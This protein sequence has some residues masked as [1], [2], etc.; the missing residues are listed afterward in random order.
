VN[1]ALPPVFERLGRNIFGGLVAASLVVG[2]AWLV[3]ST[4]AVALGAVL[5]SLAGLITL[6]HFASALLGRFR[7]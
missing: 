6:G 3:A 1:P 4:H 5:L 7:R 2:G